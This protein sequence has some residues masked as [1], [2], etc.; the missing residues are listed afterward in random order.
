MM[1][2]PLPILAESLFCSHHKTK[3]T[4]ITPFINNWLRPLQSSLPLCQTWHICEWMHHLKSKVE[5]SLTDSTFKRSRTVRNKMGESFS[6]EGSEETPNTS[7]SQLYGAV[8]LENWLYA[9]I[10]LQLLVN[11]FIELY[12]YFGFTICAFN[13]FWTLLLLS[14]P[15]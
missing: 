11:R 8:N 10:T 3:N 7:A 13:Y 6:W 4:M 5:E 14:V 15:W 9:K 1:K 2:N 12:K